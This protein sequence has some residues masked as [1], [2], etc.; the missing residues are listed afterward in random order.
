MPLVEPEIKALMQHS[1]MQ[2]HDRRISYYSNILNIILFVIII[3]TI[4]VFIYVKVIYR[5]SPAEIEEKLR[6]DQEFILSQIRYYRNQQRM[7]STSKINDLP[8]L[9]LKPDDIHFAIN[10]A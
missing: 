8:V 9:R 3:I 5:P 7:A 10:N 1:L 6:R 4:G 2:C